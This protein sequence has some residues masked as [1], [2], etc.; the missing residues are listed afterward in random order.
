MSYSFIL[1]AEEELDPQQVVDALNMRKDIEAQLDIMKEWE[2]NLLLQTKVKKALNGLIE[3]EAL[4][5]RTMLALL[6][7]NEITMVPQ[8]DFDQDKLA[9]QLLEIL[10]QTSPSLQKRSL[11]ILINL[12]GIKNT[13]LITSLNNEII[14]IFL[15]ASKDADDQEYPTALHS[16]ALKSIPVEK[17]GGK[18]IKNMIELIET[19]DKLSPAMRMALYQ[20]VGKLFL[21]KP[22]SLSRTFKADLAKVISEQLQNHPG[23]L[24]VGASQS[25]V[26]ELESLLFSIQHILSDKDLDNLVEK[27][28]PTLVKIMA[29]PNPILVKASG[30][31]LLSLQQ[32]DNRSK[33]KSPISNFFLAELGRTLKVKQPTP[34]KAIY[35]SSSLGKLVT[36]FLGS[37]EKE[38]TDQI[39][40]LVKT[41]G[42]QCFYM[43]Y[44]T[45]VRQAMLDTFFAIEPRHLADKK[46]LSSEIKKVLG[47]F[48]TAAVNHLLDPKKVQAD[49][50]FSEQL[51]K[52]LFEMSGKDL[53]LDGKQWGEWLR[54]EG[55]ELFN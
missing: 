1:S 4:P 42:P 31:A 29:L 37:E 9:E 34:Q 36:V 16:I 28:Q 11:E 8:E 13:S 40:L 21:I 38:D 12:D 27:L 23:I 6:D 30:D 49:L 55:K 22:S 45:T 54:R 53:G 10:K 5:K 2:D 43:A 17:L 19:S 18:Q 26:L 3:D 7:F 48:F 52:V 20:V 33:L 15:D 41:L 51:A 44:D 39:L 24:P 14:R 47:S 25:E 32:S 50:P 46:L 35:L